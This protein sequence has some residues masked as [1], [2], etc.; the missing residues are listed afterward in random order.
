MASGLEVSRVPGVPAP[1]TPEAEPTSALAPALTRDDL[2]AALVGGQL[3]VWFQPKIEVASGVLAGAEALLRW[4]RAGDGVRGPGELLAAA[5]RLEMSGRITRHVLDGAL[6]ACAEWLAAGRRVPVAV[7]VTPTDLADPSLPDAVQELLDRYALSGDLLILEITEGAVLQDLA[8]TSEV[9]ERLRRLGVALSIDD[10]GVG[11]SSMARLVQ[12]QL[13]ELKVD[14]SLVL[15]LHVLAEASAAVKAIIDLGHALGM[16]VVAEGVENERTLTELRS[17]GCDLAQGYLFTPALPA[18]NFLTWVADRDPARASARKPGGPHACRASAPAPGRWLKPGVDAVGGWVLAVTAAMLLI[19]VAWQVFRWGVAEHQHLIGDLAFVPVNA[20]VIVAAVMACRA[21][22][23]DR[24]T[25]WAWGLLAAAFTCYLAGTCI[26]MYYELGLREPLPFPSWADAAY[27]ISYPLIL[28]GLL[29]FPTPRRSRE[30]KVTLALDTAIVAVGGLTLIWFLD[31]APM[32]AAGGDDVLTVITSLAYPAGD[33]VLMFGAVSLLLRDP[34]RCAAGPLRLLLLG[35]G[36][37]LVTDICHSNLLLKGGYQ[38][39]D[40]IDTGWIFAQVLLVLAAAA[41]ARRP[42]SPPSQLPSPPADKGRVRSRLPYVAVAIAYSLLVVAARDAPMDP[43]GGLILAA[44]AITGLV[45]FR[46]MA[47]MREN[48]RLLRQYHTLAATDG[49]T[50][51]HNRRYLLE[52]AESAFAAAHRSDRPLSLLMIDIDNFKEINDRFGH[53][54]GDQILCAVAEACRSQ[55][56]PEDLV[57]RYGGDELIAVLLDTTTED[58]LHVAARL[59]SRLN[60]FF[61]DTSVGPVP[62]TLSIGVAGITDTRSLDALLA[63]A[64]IALYTAKREGRNC[65]RSYA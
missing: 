48:M 9:I 3:E 47:S 29:R 11:Y 65:I 63:R 31:L 5:E 33:L 4:R 49:L 50:G 57:G 30:E 45:T 52:L 60:R 22:R 16:R 15:G 51:L 13:A 56:R 14:M 1:A 32:A 21:Q 7:N 10:F 37:F 6:Q 2:Q 46:Q 53:H 58:A 61:R 40:A 26:Q 55:L 24:A 35:F 18:Q 23:H 28:I 39:G 59:Q 8:G 17:L 38:G 20:A 41:H 36:A 44:G 12:L 62:A 54:A 19:Y 64:D 25:R 27:L 43:L 34:Q 42:A